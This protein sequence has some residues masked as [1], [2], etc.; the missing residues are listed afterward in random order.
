MYMKVIDCFTF[1]NELTVLEYRLATLIDIVDHFILVEARQTHMGKDKE[2]YYLNNKERFSKYNHKI[3]HVVVDLPYRSDEINTAKDDQWRNEEFQRNCIIRGFSRIDLEDNDI[4]LVS[5]LDEIP[6]PTLLKM[7]QNGELPISIH[8]LEQDFYYYNLHSL[9]QHK[10]TMARILSFGTFEQLGLPVNG[11]RG[12]E[13]PSIKRGGWHLSYFGD[14]HFIQNKLQNFAHAEHN[15][16][17]TVNLDNIQWHIDN[18]ECIVGH[19][20]KMKRIPLNDNE[21]PPPNAD[22]Y[23]SAFI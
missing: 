20:F 1:Y 9:F 11:L 15:T 19:E 21:Y 4:L 16:P 18:T 5:D 7:V 8:K 2:L 22:T 10:W 23:L 3:I 6:D 14:K 17:T 13:C 12:Y